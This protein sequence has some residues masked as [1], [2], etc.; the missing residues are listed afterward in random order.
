MDVGKLCVPLAVAVINCGH[1]GLN[2][3]ADAVSD[4]CLANHIDIVVLTEVHL[5][6]GRPADLPGFRLLWSPRPHTPGSTRGGVALAIRDG[7]GVVSEATAIEECTRADVAWFSVII[8]SASAPLYIAA[9]YF[10]PDNAQSVCAGCSNITC[11]K[12][13]VDAGI[14][15]LVATMPRLQHNGQ[16][17]VAGDFNV[18]AQL[19]VP[20]R[21]WRAVQHDLLAPTGLL[22]CNPR[23]ANGLYTATRHDVA[24]GTDSVLDLILALPIIA[25]TGTAPTCV[26]S[27]A[28]DTHAGISDHYAL[29]VDVVLQPALSSTVVPSNY[30]FVSGVPHHLRRSLRIRGLVADAIRDSVTHAVANH[31]SSVTLQ[32][33]DVIAR[34]N[35]VERVVASVVVGAG[36]CAKRR[37]RHPVLTSAAA[38]QQRLACA[39]GRLLRATLCAQSRSDQTPAHVLIALARRVDTLEAEKRDALPAR[40]RVQRERRA[41]RRRE[42]Q[43]ELDRAWRRGDGGA[44]A[45]AQ[46]SVRFGHLTTRIRHAHVPLRQLQ[47]RLYA[48]DVGLQAKY[49]RQP[50]VL[51]LPPVDIARDGNHCVPDSMRTRCEGP[52]TP[53][54][55]QRAMARLRSQASALGLPVKALRWLMAPTSLPHIH[56]A[57]TAIWMTGVIP[58]SFTLVRASTIY[59]SG[60][61]DDVGSYRI[62][63][64]GSALSR[65]FQLLI[66]GRL[67]AQVAPLLTPAQY[68]F[69]AH[70]STEHC[71]YLA[72]S[73]VMC[74]QLEEQRVFTAYLDI[75]G[76]FGSLPHDVIHHELE[77]LGVD[78][79][80]RSLLRTWYAQQRMFVQQGRLVSPPFP[81][82]IGV[83]E[84]CAFS[85]ICFIVGIDP[86]I[87]RLE[88]AALLSN[89][90]IGLKLVRDVLTSLWYADDGWMAA[91][92]PAGLQEL[93]DIAAPSFQC[94]GLH[95]NCAPTKSAAELFPAGALTAS[96]AK[97]VRR[98]EGH[99]PPPLLTLAGQHLPFV[100]AYKYLGVMQ[101]VGGPDASRRAQLARMQVKMAA[102]LRQVASAGVHHISLLHAVR[103]YTTYWLPQV[104]YAAGLLWPSVP[105]HMT[106]WESVVLHIMMAAPHHPTVSLR[107]IAGLPTIDTRIDLDRVRVLCRLLHS[108][109]ASPVRQQLCVEV[110][111]YLRPGDGSGEGPR[112]RLWWHDTQQLLQVLDGVCDDAFRVQHR[113]FRDPTGPTSF[114]EWATSSAL[115]FQRD[116]GDA[117]VLHAALRAALFVLEGRRRARELDRCQ[118]SLGEVRDLLDTPNMAPFLA[119]TRTLA[120]A[121]RVQLRGGC[122]TLFGYQHF[123]VACCPWCGVEGQ[124]TVPHLLRDCPASEHERQALWTMAKDVLVAA[125]LCKDHDVCDHRQEWYR[126]TC[127]ASVPH[128]FVQLHLDAPTHFARAADTPAT[129]HLR[130][131][132]T[133]YRRVLHLTG[134]YLQLVVNGTFA[135][136]EQAVDALPHTAQ[137]RRPRVA[138]NH[139]RQE[140]SDALAAVDARAAL[141]GPPA[142]P[143]VVGHQDGLIPAVLPAVVL[144]SNPAATVQPVRR[145]TT[146]QTVPIPQPEVRAP[147]SVMRVWAPP[148]NTLEGIVSA[149][150]APL[151]PIERTGDG[152]VDPV[153]A[154]L[155]HLWAEPN[156]RDDE[157]HDGQVERHLIADLGAPSPPSDSD[158]VSDDGTGFE[159]NWMFGLE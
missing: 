92:Q 70:R 103:L 96:R 34:A 82:T 79:L 122:R 131:H 48:L 90:R 63:G 4:Y 137:Q 148:P 9:V 157:E 126:L 22:V 130:H 101:C 61:R 150:L 147:E 116:V 49:H 144:G 133:V 33:S 19:E 40:R 46:G 143:D 39:R 42:A 110:S 94:R 30:G 17:I 145:P 10:P 37:I 108:P 1:G 66:N 146:L 86:G 136:L 67:M 21:R 78:A 95:F 151:P 11:P 56:A 80:T 31:L 120:T 141:A 128:A 158:R 106:K 104:T 59:K 88:Q 55:V 118:A 51:D 26:R 111:L 99:Q 125:G 54:E 64:V 89:H 97:V 35:T 127:G 77:V 85:P 25:P 129:R 72:T 152:V 69:L 139:H 159:H 138:I 57:M 16:V 117:R 105:V 84:G 87:R 29:L 6:P 142:D 107:S 5:P 102:I 38:Q 15:Y 7:V 114:L 115:A 3:A 41:Q 132:M 27:V 23:D 32:P 50:P 135:Q 149:A 43:D 36:L 62:I 121:C 52:P 65:V 75:A 123:H 119:D 8:P 98:A 153:L 124:F 45:G 154:S 83:T 81:C 44:Y 156:V 134:Q 53:E 58:P 68:G 73:A 28:I 76:A 20:S 112:K 155:L 140:R 74:A 24:M 47:A 100:P 71:V 2:T 109:P 93:L 113:I 14:A 18:Q 12:S 60:P 91:L 13:H